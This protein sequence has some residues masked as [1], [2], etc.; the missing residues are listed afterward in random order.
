MF[1]QTIHVMEEVKRK[2]NL[3]AQAALPC[4]IGG[5]ARIQ[6]YDIGLVVTDFV[7]LEQDA[8]GATFNIGKKEINDF[9]QKMVDDKKLDQLHEWCSIIHSHP[10]GC[11]PFLSG[12]DV[13]AIKSLAQEGHAFSLIME[14]SAKADSNNFKMHFCVDTEVGHVIVDNIAVRT[15]I[16]Q[17]SADEQEN[18]KAEVKK[19]LRPPVRHVLPRANHQ[20]DWRNDYK[21][22]QSA[23][24]SC[25][26][27]DTHSDYLIG[28][29]VH[30]Y[31]VEIGDWVQIEVDI[32][33]LPV[34]DWGSV[35]DEIAEFDGKAFKVTAVSPQGVTAGGRQW[36]NHEI[37]V[38]YQETCDHNDYD[39]AYS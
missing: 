24:S 34:G 14:A 2:F 28:A 3:Y 13:E 36:R 8:T 4:E 29:M 39:W 5:L 20:D 19:L 17:A 30:N 35:H 21:S 27:Y 7:I 16:S 6:E 37:D 1:P 9:T 22:R 11:D 23:Q 10:V 33:R 18:I 12:T 31:Q 38:L 15:A 25:Q 26:K 32:S